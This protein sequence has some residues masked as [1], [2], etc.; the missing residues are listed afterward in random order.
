[1]YR[2]KEEKTELRNKYLDNRKKLDD[3]TKKQRDEAICNLFTS[4]VSY[5]YAENI[6]MFYP[7]ASEI[8]VRP[9]MYKALADGKRVAFPRCAPDGSPNMEFHYVT[10]EDDM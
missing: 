10:S 9:I 4:L 5:K 1:M 2:S 8:D 6:L 7:K 3:Q